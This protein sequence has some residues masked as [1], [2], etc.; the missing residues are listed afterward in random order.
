MLRP[1]NVKKLPQ[2]RVRVWI[3]Q[4]SAG[5][6][7]PH[8]GWGSL[9]QHPQTITESGMLHTAARTKHATQNGAKQK[10]KVKANKARKNTKP[11]QNQ[12]KQTKQF[13]KHR[14]LTGEKC[15]DSQTGLGWQGL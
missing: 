2:N 14:I 1:R 4:G 13:Y 8:Q 10:E 9:S 15:T 12:P 7:V 3:P 5:R 6:E 11:K